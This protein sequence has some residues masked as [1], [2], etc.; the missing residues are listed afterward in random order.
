MPWQSYFLAF[1][2][3]VFALKFPVPALVSLAVL[4]AVDTAFRGWV[5]R[6]PLLAFVLCAAFGFGYASQRAPEPPPTPAWVESKQ[7]AEL[8][9]VVRSVEP[10]AGGR[11]RVILRHVTC[12]VDGS[13]QPLE[14]L[15]TWTM[16]NPKVT[17]L[18]GQ[19]FAGAMRVVPVRS[20]GNPGGWDYAWYWR[21]RGVN[22]RAW[23]AGRYAVQDWGPPPDAPLDQAKQTLRSR[24]DS[25]LPDNESGSI[26]RALV[27]GD[28]SGLDHAFRKKVQQAGLAHTLALSGLHVGFVAAMGLGLAWLAG[29]VWPPLLLSI[30]RR[31]LAVLFAAPL[32]L[33]YAWIGQPSQSLIRAAVMFGFWGFFLLQGR[34]RV[35]MDGLFF[36]LLVIVLFHP[37]A[38]FDT[39][40]QM[41]GLAVAGIGF[42]YPKIRNL[43][44]FGERWPLRLVGWAGGL[45][46]LSVCANLA[47]MPVVSWTF[48][49]WAPNI[50][51]NV[52]WVPVLGMVVMPLGLA[53]TVLAPF[54]WAEPAAASLLASAASVMEWL[55]ALLYWVGEH[56]LTPVFSVLRPLW[57][58][59]L[60]A[61]VL[62]VA[63]G[64]AWVDRRV[65]MTVVALGWLLLMVPH[66]MV[67][68]LDARD[69]VTITTL[70]VGL[71]QAVVVSTPGG[72]RW[73]VDGAGGSRTFDRGE[74]LV[75][76]SLTYGRP[77]RL[78]GVFMSHPDADHSYGLPFILSRFDAGTFFT[79]GAL[80][81]RGSR[82]GEYMRQVLD[83]E[84]I[85][86]D[87]LVA[88]DV[89]DLGGGASF[90]VV[91]PA[92]GFSNSH[93]NEKSLVLRLLWHGQP[94]ALLPGD[95]ESDG[96]DSLLQSGRRV[97][98]E[99]LVL[100]HHG[101]KTSFVPAFY[102]AVSPDLAVSSN[103]YLN[104]YGFPHRIVREGI[105]VPLYTTGESGQIRIVWKRG[106]ERRVIAFRKE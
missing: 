49:V 71:G 52:I 8:R 70:D 48:G 38:V 51:L 15:V 30:P 78:D 13:V 41:S 56:G 64:V 28:K 37:L 14:G 82:T 27:T 23:P 12:E 63:A 75:A 10:R 69:E 61:G 26:V 67:M 45:L 84:K 3:G 50:L 100:P 17:P 99:V 25:L 65:H 62:L 11:L 68:A 96:I 35:L 97:S 58:E 39:S 20:F 103:G 89:V 5:R 29:L 72:H 32:V 6:L 80:P 93:A 40:L 31:K 102:A 83:E 16:R 81:R 91:H 104:R 95:V 87:V 4:W 7:A 105:G 76:P 101:S 59:M 42:L 74:A 53:G 22:W 106:G 19:T 33:G 60:G 2:S 54:G 18:P 1:V 24:V 44:S 94:L 88:G 34:G 90:E 73:L 77:P 92:D 43:F 36:A 47:L 9:G 86:P 79:N 85:T 55:V 21:C 66:G 46:G 98:A 57:P